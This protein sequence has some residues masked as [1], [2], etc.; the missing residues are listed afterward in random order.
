[1]DCTLGRLLHLEVE[2][3]AVIR[4]LEKIHLLVHEVE[5]DLL[6]RSLAEVLLQLLKFTRVR[7]CS[8][9]EAYF[10]AEDHIVLYAVLV[11]EVR[12]RCC[13]FVCAQ[14]IKNYEDSLLALE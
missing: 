12:Q 3:S 8:E 14:Q 2:L 10:S 7:S 11:L 9:Q 6:G 13:F 1:M 4:V 5:E